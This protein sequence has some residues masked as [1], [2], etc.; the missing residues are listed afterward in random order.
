[1]VPP[2]AGVNS[3]L[4]E[5]LSMKLAPLFG[6]LVAF[7]LASHAAAQPNPLVRPLPTGAASTEVLG[8]LL[9]DLAFQ[10]KA[11]SPDVFQ[12]TVERDRWPVHIMS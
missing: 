7:V 10:P 1:M 11:L 8:A 4:R 9:R 6:S 12:V 3:P 5:A 2:V